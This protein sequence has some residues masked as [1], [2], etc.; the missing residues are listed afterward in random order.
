[1]EARA[2]RLC[3][4][5]A[6]LECF[7][8]FSSKSCSVGSPLRI[9][10]ACE[11]FESVFHFFLARSTPIYLYF[12][13]LV[14]VSVETAPHMLCKLLVLFERSRETSV[15]VD[16]QVSSASLKVQCLQI[17]VMVYRLLK[18]NASEICR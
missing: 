3:H 11:Y 2:A 10:R 7:H 1:M 5:S 9:R 18:Q 13:I 8:L 16:S 6:I 12:P 14:A 17:G 4:A 15:G